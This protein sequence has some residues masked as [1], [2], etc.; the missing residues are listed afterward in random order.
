MEQPTL[1]NDAIAFDTHRFVKH[2]TKAGFTE[3]QAEAMAE[4]QVSLLNSNL[5]TKADLKAEIAMLDADL[6]AEMAMLDADLK[7]EMARLDADLKAEMARLDADLR[8]E[9]ARLEKELKAE[10]ARVENELKAEIARV[11]AGLKAE[12]ARIDSTIAQAKTET[13]K[14][15]AGIVLGAMVVQVTAVVGLFLQLL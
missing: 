14:W 1:M 15:I 4:E 9:I 10:I 2:M 6:K 3:Q 7:A 12:S 13:I 5:A 11:E 8:A